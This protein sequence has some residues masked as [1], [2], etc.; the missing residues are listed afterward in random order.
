MPTM[1]APDVSFVKYVNIYDKVVINKDI[2]VHVFVKGN[3]AISNATADAYGYN[4][5]SETFTQTT[6][7]NQADAT[8]YLGR[9][10]TGWIAPALPGALIRSP[11]RQLPSSVLCVSPQ[12]EER[13]RTRPPCWGLFV[14]ERRREHHRPARPRC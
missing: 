6:S 5:H 3:S 13:R 9:T 11:H 8:P 10:S 7:A 4:T 1:P 14:W 2:D 12:A